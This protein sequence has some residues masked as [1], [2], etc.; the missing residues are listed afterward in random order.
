MAYLN[1][2][3]SQYFPAPAFY[4]GTGASQLVPDVFPVAING[5]PYMLDMA[6]NQFNRQY[7]ARVRDSVGNLLRLRSERITA[8]AGRLK[9]Q[10]PIQFRK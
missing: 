1:D 10:Y 4:T 2:F 7:D 3:T 5:R 6:S 9:A 8:E